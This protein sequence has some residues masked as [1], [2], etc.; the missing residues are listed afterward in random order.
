M[1][2]RG[3]G[4]RATRLVSHAWKSEFV[5][6]V[7]NIV[8]DATE[9][10]T[11]VLLERCAENEFNPYFSAGILDADRLLQRLGAKELG[12]CYWLCIFAVNEHRAICGD[13][14]HCN[15]T[16]QWRRDP[17]TFLRAP[18]CLLCHR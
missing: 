1:R 2:N 8:M 9:W 15:K 16:L 4:K 17:K 10:S 5:N 6:T 11:E 13:C 3:G 14:W 12:R 7:M 18:R